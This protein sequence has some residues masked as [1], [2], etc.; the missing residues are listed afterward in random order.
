MPPGE[1]SSRSGRC[2]GSSVTAGDG[3]L[4]RRASEAGKQQKAARPPHPQQQPS[5]RRLIA[6]PLSQQS[7]PG[8]RTRATGRSG[9]R[10]CERA[11]NRPGTGRRRASAEHRSGSPPQRT[12]APR[13]GRR[14]ERTRRPPAAARENPD[15]DKDPSASEGDE[16]PAEEVVPALPGKQGCSERSER[17]PPCVTTPYALSAWSHSSRPGALAEGGCDRGVLGKHGIFA[18]FATGRKYVRS[19]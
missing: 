14:Q 7:A 3:R 12:R 10:G 18:I 11:S 19:P 4:N 2:V 15:G 17:N 13:R 5:G 8:A 6:A 9:I 1:R 16:A